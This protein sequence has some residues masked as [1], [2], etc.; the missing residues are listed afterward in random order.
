MMSGILSWSSGNLGGRGTGGRFWASTLHS[1][2]LSRYLLFNS[3]EVNPKHGSGK[4][5]GLT[6]RC[7]TRPK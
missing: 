2:T 5:D 6:L 7:V 1:Y 3:T 4:P